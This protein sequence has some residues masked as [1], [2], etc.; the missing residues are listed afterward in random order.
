MDCKKIPDRILAAINNYV[1]HGQGAGFFVGAILLNNLM[2]A[3][4][5]ADKESL[6]ALGDIVCYVR[7]SIPEAC[8]GSCDK[9]N[10][11]ILQGGA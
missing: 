6:K 9:V 5:Y 1:L 2:D 8:I 11:W 3:V 4:M 7:H 10:A